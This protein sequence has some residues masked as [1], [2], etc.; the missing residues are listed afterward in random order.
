MKSFQSSPERLK[1]KKEFKVVSGFI[2][3]NVFSEIFFQNIL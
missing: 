3:K 1:K 2:F